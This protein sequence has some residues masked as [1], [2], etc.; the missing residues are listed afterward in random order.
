MELKLKI[1]LKKKRNDIGKVLISEKKLID[2]RNELLDKELNIVES[3]TEN[4]IEK[5]THCDWE[6][7]YCQMKKNLI[8]NKTELFGQKNSKWL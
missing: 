1:K 6:V 8:E 2:K 7:I 4:R 3:E 5:S